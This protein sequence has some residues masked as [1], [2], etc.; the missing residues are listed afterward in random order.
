MDKV[1]P[2]Q[3]SNAGT[4]AVCCAGKT[5]GRPHQ[6]LH[7]IPVSSTPGFH[8]DFTSTC[9]TNPHNSKCCDTLRSN[10]SGP[11]VFYK[12]WPLFEVLSPQAIQVD[13]VVF[14]T[15]SFPSRCYSLHLFT[16]WVYPTCP[17]SSTQGECSQWW[18]TW[19]P[20]LILW[21]GMIKN[22]PYE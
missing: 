1:A 4:E 7:Q 8:I 15:H 9:Q 13:P 12:K 2:T 17:T 11:F 22:S 21:P 18:R 10:V 14:S 20:Q 3:G 6:K 5:L 19:P 16:A